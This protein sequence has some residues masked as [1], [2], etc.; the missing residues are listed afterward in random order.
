M[1][2][3]DKNNFIVQISQNSCTL[4]VRDIFH[5]KIQ[6]SALANFV[7][8]SMATYYTRQ[9][10][11]A[12]HFISKLLDQILTLRDKDKKKDLI[13]WRTFLFFLITAATNK[14]GLMSLFSP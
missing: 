11:Q 10:V 5:T 9:A 13:C 6:Q 14:G 2:M 7:F 4:L 1:D 3:L 12:G 8:I